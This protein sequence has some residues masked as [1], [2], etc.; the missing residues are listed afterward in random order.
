MTAAVLGDPPACQGEPHGDAPAAARLKLVV[1]EDVRPLAWV[2]G[3][4]HVF[5]FAPPRA[6]TSDELT[7]IESLPTAGRGRCRAGPRARCPP[8]TPRRRAPPAMFG[9]KYGDVVRVVDVRRRSGPV[10]GHARGQH[11]GNRRVQNR[12]RGGH[13]RRRAP[14]RG[15]R[16]PG[17]GG[18]VADRDEV[19]SALARA[20]RAP[21]GALGRRRLA[22]SWTTACARA[23]TEAEALRG[24][25]PRRRAKSVALAADATTAPGG[26]KVLVAAPGRRRPARPSSRPAR[27]LAASAATPAAASPWC[28][29]RGAPSGLVAFDEAVQKAGGL[30]AGA[31]LGAAAKACG[32][33]GGKPASRRRAATS[34]ARATVAAPRRR[35]ERRREASRS[36]RRRDSTPGE[37]HGRTRAP[38]RPC[39]AASSA[40]LV[41][42]SLASGSRRQWCLAAQ[43]R[44]ARGRPRRRARVRTRGDA[45]HGVPREPSE[46]Q[47]GCD[48]LRRQRFRVGRSARFR[49]RPWRGRRRVATDQVSH[50]AWRSRRGAASSGADPRR[51]GAPAPRFTR[52]AG[53]PRRPHRG[54]ATK[55]SGNDVV[56][57]VVR[58][59]VREVS[60]MSSAMAPGGRP[61]QDAAGTRRRERGRGRVGGGAVLAGGRR[62]QRCRR[63]RRLNARGSVRAP[64]RSSFARVR[65]DITPRIRRGRC[66]RRRARRARRPSPQQPPAAS[67]AA[68]PAERLELLLLVRLLRLEQRGRRRRVLHRVVH[69]AGARVGIPRAPDDDRDRAA[70]RGGHPQRHVV[71]QVVVATAHAAQ[72]RRGHRCCVR[73]DAE[74]RAPRSRRT[75]GRGLRDAVATDDARV[76]ASPRRCDRRRLARRRVCVPPAEVEISFPCARSPLGRRPPRAGLD[77]TDGDA[78]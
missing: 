54:L 75:G 8:P 15:G 61:R 24:V 37:L 31:V 53:S 71:Q 27:E 33:G 26:Q 50:A 9:E 46:R 72:A 13:R 10:R 49:R 12:L 36:Y 43:V 52:V 6:P 16:R 78:L 58:D 23:Q 45:R 48:I 30:K 21:R 17:R 20:P 62:R 19:V 69:V 41:A 11:R 18:H 55:D 14:D 66:R 2:T 32:G 40:G 59:V 4:P 22:R 3:L 76:L 5:D 68:C 56:R 64:R 73:T 1:G 67:V 38:S 47:P 25:P 65:G 28:W 77:L 39:A 42:S 74:A 70:R 7:A 57:E 44:R 63:Y 60:A 35:D 51:A 34:T 29:A